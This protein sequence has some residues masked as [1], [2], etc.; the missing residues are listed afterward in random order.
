[1]TN[2][3]LYRVSRDLVTKA[4]R[5]QYVV[6]QSLRDVVLKGVHDDAGHQG[7]LRSLGLTRQRFFW[8]NLDRDVGPLG[9]IA[10][11]RSMQLVSID[12][13]SLSQ[14]KTSETSP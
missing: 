8:L 7:Q 13:C 11:T 3:V 2:G 10:S 12:F 4:K 6:P 14:L 9:S 1:M 5:F